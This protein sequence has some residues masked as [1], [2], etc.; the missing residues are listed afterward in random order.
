MAIFFWPAGT[1]SGL[2][3]MGR[4]LSGPIR[5]RVGYGFLKKNPKR[6]RV[7]L[8][9]PRPDP[10]PDPDKTRYSKITKIP[11]L[12]IYTYHLTLN[13]ISHFFTTNS[14]ARTHASLPQSSPSLRQCEI[15]QLSYRRSKLCQCHRSQALYSLNSVSSSSSPISHCHTVLCPSHLPRPWPQAWHSLTPPRSPFFFSFLF[16]WV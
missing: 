5:N 2:I 15:G 6:V 14:E 13:L 12:Y 7:L 10:K 3:L 8:K 9:N 11:L 16:F 1:R 4:V